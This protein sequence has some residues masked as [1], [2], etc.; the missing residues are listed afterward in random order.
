MPEYMLSVHHV[1]NETTPN[2]D[3][4]HRVFDE[5]ER[6]WLARRWSPKALDT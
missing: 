5:A 1:D 2:G 6:A 3:D 4:M